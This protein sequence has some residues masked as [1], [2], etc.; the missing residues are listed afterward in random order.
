MI[1]IEKLSVKVGEKSILH[2]ISINFEIGK[3][4]LILG[5]NGSGKSSLAGFLMWNPALEYVSGSVQFD[6]KNL[7]EMTVDERSTAGL[8]LSF[9]NIPEIQWVNVREYLR[10]IYNAMLK[11]HF[12][13]TPALTPFVFKR[14][15]KKYLEELEI[16]EVFLERDLHV[17][18]SWWEKRKIE[19]LQV[20][21]LW[22]K[23]II[24]D[25]IDS[26]LDVDAFKLVAE[27][28]VSLNTKNNSIIVITHHFKIVE[29]IDFDT[30][31]VLKNGKLHKQWWIQILDEIRE[32]GFWE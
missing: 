21:L 13:D 14:F 17:G 18:F 12:P 28:I 7:Q 15:I 6:G 16:P 3:N 9:Q 30:V 4:Y 1:E 25:E 27:L 26:W 10:T 29:Y 11:T 2:D 31:Y 5:K 8:F 19:M 22:P 24:F 23:Y 32:H 20:K